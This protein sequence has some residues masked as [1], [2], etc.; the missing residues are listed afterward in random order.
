MVAYGPRLFIQPILAALMDMY[1]IK[2]IRQHVDRRM[3]V[4]CVYVSLTMFFSLNLAT[5]TLAN[6]TEGA[7]FM[8]S[9]FHWQNN[10]D[11]T[12]MCSEVHARLFITLNFLIRSTSLMVWPLLFIIR[13]CTLPKH[14]RG[15]YFKV[16]ILHAIMSVM[17]ALLID[18]LYFGKCLFTAWNFIDWNVIQGLSAYFS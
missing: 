10:R 5:R 18:Y 1:L 2:Y 17:L 15:L 8:L 7:L 6:S 13:L 9:F 3:P 11:G 16:N 12:S 14:K 4:I